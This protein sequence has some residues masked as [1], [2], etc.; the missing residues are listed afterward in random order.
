MTPY[1]RNAPSR[2]WRV[3]AQALAGVAAFTIGVGLAASPARTWPNLL[4]ADVYLLS[5][6]LSGAL[7]VAI[8]FMCVVLC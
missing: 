5:V 3:S 6:A 1:P 8:E 7:F 4:L 2:S